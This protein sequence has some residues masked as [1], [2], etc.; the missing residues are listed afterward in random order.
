MRGGVAELSLV[1][2]GGGG[3]CVSDCLKNT[4]LSFTRL[5][6]GEKGNNRLNRDGLSTVPS[7]SPSEIHTRLYAEVYLQ[8][9]NRQELI[10]SIRIYR[11][12][13]VSFLP[14]C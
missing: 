1:N 8:T 6:S 3:D 5:Q 13:E 4:V 2:K 10:T 14:M 7:H 11:F 9:C 12:D